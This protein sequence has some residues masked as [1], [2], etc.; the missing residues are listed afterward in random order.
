MSVIVDGERRWTWPVSTGL[1][2]YDTP[3]GGYTTFRMERDHRSREWDD[4]PMPHSIFF[5]RAGHAIHGSYSI[6]RLGWPASHGCVRVA[7]KNAAQLFALV[8]EHGLANTQVVIE[9]ELPSALPRVAVP[10]PRNRRT[11]LRQLAKLEPPVVSAAKPNITAIAVRRPEASALEHRAFAPLPP[12]HRANRQALPEQTI[13][14]IA[15]HEAPSVAEPERGPAI[16]AARTLGTPAEQRRALA[17][18]IPLPRERG[19]AMRALPE[20]AMSVIAEPKAPAIADAEIDPTAVAVHTPETPVEE[21]RTIARTVPTPRE[22]RSEI[23]ALAEPEAPVAATRTTSAVAKAE[24]GPTAAADRTLET[25][26]EVRQV[27]AH[28]VL[29]PTELRA[30]QQALPEPEIR[31]ATE[32]KALATAHADAEADETAVAAHAPETPVKER[33]ASARAVPLPPE[34]RAATQTEAEPPHREAVRDQSPQQTKRRLPRPQALPVPTPRRRT[35]RAYDDPPA[36]RRPRSVYR[37]PV[38]QRRWARRTP[39]VYYDPRV[40]II[41]EFYVNGHWVRR[42][43]YRRARPRDFYDW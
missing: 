18:V 11:A 13:S 3:N 38:Y 36:Y 12:E 33:V 23:R 37:P 17:H 1:T 26:A 28:T 16:I 35:A 41:Q 14:N 27:S 22:H 9:G 5:T 25:S 20:P 21:R 24:S 40:E 10:L 39:R 7:P 6:R 2:K 42:R 43:Y 32:R 29:L 31:V 19:A 15:S 4:A 8:R 30:E 34:R